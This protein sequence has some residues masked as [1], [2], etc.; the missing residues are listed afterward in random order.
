MSTKFI[1]QIQT[2]GQMM[3]SCDSVAKCDDELPKLL[4]SDLSWWCGDGLFPLLSVY[5]LAASYYNGGGRGAAATLKL[6]I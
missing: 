1:Y 2:A 3:Q 4:G 6:N 5:L